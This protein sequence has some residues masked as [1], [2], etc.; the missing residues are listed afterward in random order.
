MSMAE[1]SLLMRGP[2]EV[3]LACVMLLLVKVRLQTVSNDWSS[4]A[5]AAPFQT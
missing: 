1:G 5:L 2:F 4:F 3:E